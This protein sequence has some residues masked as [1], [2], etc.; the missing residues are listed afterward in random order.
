MPTSQKIIFVIPWYGKDATG[1]AEIQCKTLAEHLHES[2]LDIEIYTTCSKQF[3]GEWKDDLKPGKYLEDQISVT[4]FKLDQRNKPLFD[5]INQKIISLQKI[6][7]Q[8]EKDF[9]QNNINSKDLINAIKK[10]S[11]SLFIFMPYLYEIGRA[12]V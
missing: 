7:L 4:R 1:G 12:H 9:F 10:D 11:T 6:S 5:S 3:Q 8:E 2:G